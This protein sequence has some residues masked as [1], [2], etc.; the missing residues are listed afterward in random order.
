MTQQQIDFANAWMSLFQFNV[1]DIVHQLSIKQDFS[2][3]NFSEDEAIS[4]WEHIV[5]HVSRHV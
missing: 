4:I 3:P 1:R 2:I 5:D